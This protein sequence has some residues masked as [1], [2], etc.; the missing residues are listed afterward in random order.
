MNEA[1]GEISVAFPHLLFFVKV[2]EEGEYV[3]IEA[4]VDFKVLK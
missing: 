1:S 2:E 4:N 3:K